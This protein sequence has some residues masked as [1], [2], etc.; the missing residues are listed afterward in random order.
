MN[1]EFKPLS[2]HFGAEVLGVDLSQPID[3]ETFSAI[4]KAYAKYGVLVFRDQTLTEPDFINFTK[5]FGELHIYP[6]A[7][8]A[9]KTYPEILVL[10]NIVDDEGNAIGLNDGG[11]T[12]HTD[13]SYTKVPPRGTF[14]Y[15]LEVPIDDSG[16][17]LGD[18]VFSSV[19]A[20]YD[21]LPEATKT[22]LQGRTTT[23]SYEGKHTLRMKIGKYKR[24]P[25]TKEI[26]DKLPPVEHP[27]IRVHPQSGR[28]C[29]YVIAG[30]CK[31]ISGMPDDEAETLLDDLAERCHRPEYVYAHQWR[32][33]DVVFWDNCVVQHSATQNYDLPLRRLLW[34]T[35]IKGSIPAAN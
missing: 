23:H 29:I 33:G 24:K 28:K 7:E 17:A 21:D 5:R 34:R 2:D 18:T 6:L 11:S 22:L 19:T 8:Y 20:A 26:L 4:E 12:W 10:S 32:K 31:G 13:N 30:E 35:T 9:H 3:D 25:M 1:L 27:V 15:S 16:N 14:L